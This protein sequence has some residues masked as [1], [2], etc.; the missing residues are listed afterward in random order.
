MSPPRCAAAIIRSKRS[1][2]VQPIHGAG[3][4]CLRIAFFPGRELDSSLSFGQ[5]ERFSDNVKWE[6]A[7]F[8]A[9]L[10]SRDGSHARGQE[11]DLSIYSL[12]V[13]GFKKRTRSLTL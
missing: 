1:P 6:Y 5:C 13:S 2:R 4:R 9:R 3:S 12:W 7:V 11:I 10:N 8:K